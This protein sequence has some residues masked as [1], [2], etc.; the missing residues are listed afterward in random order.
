MMLFFTCGIQQPL[1]LTRLCIEVKSARSFRG[2][3]R[4]TH[5]SVLLLVISPAAYRIPSPADALGEA[6]LLRLSRPGFSKIQPEYSV[7]LSR[8]S[9]CG[10]L[11]VLY[12]VFSPGGGCRLISSARIAF[13][14]LV[15]RVTRRNFSLSCFLTRPDGISNIAPCG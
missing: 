13:T 12:V 5:S 11:S 14:Q 10:I 15:R 4:R 2:I 7:G 9:A 3:H 6:N 1:T 8:L